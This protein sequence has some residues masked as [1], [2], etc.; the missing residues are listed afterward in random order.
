[1][2]VN[3]KDD[4]EAKRDVSTVITSLADTITT[5]DNLL[6][7]VTIDG[8]HVSYEYISGFLYC[9]SLIF[10]SSLSCLIYVTFH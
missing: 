1:M 3:L 5:A 10:I 2:L 8:Y 7:Q 4:E 6:H 9:F